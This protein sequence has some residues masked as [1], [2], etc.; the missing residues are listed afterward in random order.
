M[1]NYATLKSA[2]QNT[3]KQNGNNEITGNLLQNS[4]I[5]MINSLGLGHQ[6][7]GVLVPGGASPGTPDQ[8]VFYFGFAPGTYFN[9]TT[10]RTGQLGVFAYNG[11]WSVAIF[12]VNTGLADYLLRVK[13][14]KDWGD[15][16]VNPNTTTT[17]AYLNP[18]GE[19]RTAN[20]GMALRTL[21]PSW[22]GT[23]KP[24][25]VKFQRWLQLRYMILTK[26]V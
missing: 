8:N 16:L 11:S 5:T 12:D 14:V 17:S 24:M 7:M 26:I 13:A 20:P 2:I 3:I 21:Y 4:L 19:V 25:P 6:Y 22:A 1:A 15:N 10:L 9:G 18:D 23:L